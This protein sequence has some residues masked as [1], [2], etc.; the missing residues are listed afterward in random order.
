MIRKPK[1][2]TEANWNQNPTETDWIPITSIGFGWEFH[3][4]KISISVGQHLENQSKLNWHTPKTHTRP[5]YLSGRVK[6]DPLG[7]GQTRYPRVE[8]LL[9]SLF[10]IVVGGP[11]GWNGKGASYCQ[12]SSIIFHCWV[13]TFPFYF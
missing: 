3:K 7:L 12:L 4:P 9:P 1:K 5:Y 2:P 10:E 13:F 11:W 8:L 6:S